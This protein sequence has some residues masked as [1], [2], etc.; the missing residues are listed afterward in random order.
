MSLKWIYLDE[1]CTPHRST[2]SPSISRKGSKG[3]DRGRWQWEWGWSL[4]RGEIKC[5]IFCH[6]LWLCLYMSHMEEM[7]NKWCLKWEQLSVDHL[8]FMRSACLQ[9][10]SNTFTPTCINAHTHLLVHTTSM[11]TRTDSYTIALLPNDIPGLWASKCV[12]PLSGLCCIIFCIP[13]VLT[14]K[15][16]EALPCMPKQTHTLTYKHLPCERGLRALV[17][18]AGQT[19]W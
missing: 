6:S 4:E 16:W 1:F 8:H 15:G 13:S 2:G 18:S 3:R 12:F 17:S 7:I 10:W 19:L 9:L 14:G 5:G 11:T